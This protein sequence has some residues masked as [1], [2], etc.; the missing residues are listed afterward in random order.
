MFT[1]RCLS[2]RI[3]TRSIISYPFRHLTLDA[4]N[5][6]IH[7]EQFQST[8]NLIREDLHLIHRDILQVSKNRFIILF[9]YLLDFLF[10]KKEWLHHL[11]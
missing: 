1:F 2:N 4:A 10:L 3:L 9:L 11:Y 8:A 6:Q 5:L 7:N